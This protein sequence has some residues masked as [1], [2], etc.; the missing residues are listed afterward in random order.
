[1]VRAG[2]RALEQEERLYEAKL[3]ALKTAL[4]EGERSGFAENSSLDGILAE[5]T[6]AGSGS[7]SLASASAR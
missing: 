1:V 7:A 2:L 5:C 3:A 4:D 6:G